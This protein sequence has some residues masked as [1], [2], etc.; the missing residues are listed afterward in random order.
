[1]QHNRENEIKSGLVSHAPNAGLRRLPRRWR[2]YGLSQLSHI[3]HKRTFLQR[4]DMSD[5]TRL[6]GGDAIQPGLLFSIFGLVASRDGRLTAGF[7]GLVA[8]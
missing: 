5:G 6:G 3:Q 7:V 2:W 4:F 1:M 8:N